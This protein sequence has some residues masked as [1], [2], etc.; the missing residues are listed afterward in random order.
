MFSVSV[1]YGN[2]SWLL[3]FHKEETAK[4]AIGKLYGLPANIGGLVIPSE[5]EVTDDFGQTMHALTPP[6]AAMFEDMDKSKMLHVEINLHRARMQQE[7][8]K[9]AETDQALRAR[10]PAILQPMM[11]P[12][13]NGFR[14]G[15]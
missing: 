5:R 11:G 14:G 15:N 4:A 3:L 13:P 10:G 12:G 8:V 6:I 7:V 2:T 1:I 9:R